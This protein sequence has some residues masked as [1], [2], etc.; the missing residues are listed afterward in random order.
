MTT[1]TRARELIKAYV[2]SYGDAFMARI[3]LKF[4]RAHAFDWEPGERDAY[5]R[6]IEILGSEMGKN[7][8]GANIRR[9]NPQPRKKPAKRAKSYITRNSQA[10]RAAPSKRLKARRAK[11]ASGAAPKGYFPNP[12][13]KKPKMWIVYPVEKGLP[14]GKGNAYF[15]KKEDAVA[16]AQLLAD[17]NKRV[18]A[19]DQ[20]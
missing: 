10:T 20:E 12:R 18:Y 13:A 9:K 15:P 16:F 17:E 11:V 6:A 8:M 7:K 5:D 3:R 1:E 4:V 19:V 14:M 2:R